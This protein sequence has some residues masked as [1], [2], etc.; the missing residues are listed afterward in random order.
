MTVVGDIATRGRAGGRRGWAAA[1]TVG[2]LFATA[3][4][5]FPASDVVFPHERDTYAGLAR[6]VDA[7]A[8]SLRALGVGGGDQVGTLMVPGLDLVAALG[9]IA[10]LGAVAV[11]INARF[12]HQEL[13]HVIPD[14]D[15][16]VL[17]LS[18]PVPGHADHPALV[19]AALELTDAPEL[20]HI[21]LME[22]AP[23]PQPGVMARATFDA[24]GETVDPADLDRLQE[25]VRLRDLAIIMYT[26]GTEAHPKG[27]LL[28]HE[29]LVRT[30]LGIAHTRFR[31][32]AEDRMWMPLPL[33]HCGGI[34]LLFACLVAGTSYVH[35][36]FF[37]PAVALE[38]LEDE[39][40]T[41]AHPAFETIWLAVLNH[42]NFAKADLSRVRIVLAVGVPERL[43][44]MHER[45]PHA[46]PY[47]SFGATE[48]CSHLALS[49]PD[50]PLEPR[51]TTGG[52]PLPGMEIRIVDPD[53]GADLPSDVEGEVLY[54]GPDLFSGYHKSPELNA[55][56]FDED[57]WFHS[58]DVGTL[59][60]DGRLTFRSRLKD[61]LKVGG[62]NVAAAEIENVIAEHPAVQIVQVVSAPDERYVEVPAAFVQ[63][64]PGAT[65][66]AQDIVDQ[67]AGRIASFKV[68]RHVRFV[69]DWPMSGTKIRKVALR[70]RIRDELAAQ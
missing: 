18:A 57:G 37:D 58:K 52:H 20:K 54:R 48:A 38:Q 61:M 15:M 4:A 66:T 46:M 16:R 8:R 1:T 17:L 42:P 26:S 43:R 67:C 56:C 9:A 69:D 41:I 31:L 44:G 27:C 40:I 22:D 3:A 24:L 32:T 39:R 55:E 65:A 33:F 51:F 64:N 50:D 28:T 11:P 35:A 30:A 29:A 34:V 62:E 23:E 53:T 14:S 2:D 70:E 12:K 49:V 25:R 36:G 68:P 47:C 7:L 60:A 21:V 45:L 63:L 13:A 59:D 19:R 10:Q 5:A 6:R